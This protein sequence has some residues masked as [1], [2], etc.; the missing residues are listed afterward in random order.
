MK[1]GLNL[2]EKPLMVKKS[3]SKSLDGQIELFDLKHVVT[4]YE[5]FEEKLGIKEPYEFSIKF[6]DGASEP[7]TKSNFIL[8]TGLAS[9][10]GNPV[11]GLTLNFLKS[12]NAGT[13]A[14]SLEVTWWGKITRVHFHI[15]A[16]DVP[17]SKIYWAKSAHADIERLL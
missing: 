14:L 2:Q 17:D 7:V 15:Y 10:K 4:A 11:E 16:K 13:Q 8:K 3:F 9:Q 12:T 6:Q 5:L 1:K